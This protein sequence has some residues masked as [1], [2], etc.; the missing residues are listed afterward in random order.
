MEASRPQQNNLIPREAF[1]FHP[2]EEQF[3]VTSKEQIRIIFGGM[4]Q[5]SVEENKKIQ[6]FRDSVKDKPE[7]ATLQDPMYVCLK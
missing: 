5:L 7:V 1:M 3:I 2:K 6:D 4:I